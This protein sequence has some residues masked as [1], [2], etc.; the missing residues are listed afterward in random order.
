MQTGHGALLI[1]GQPHDIVFFLK[2][3]CHLNARSVVSQSS[4]K[5][6]YRAMANLILKMI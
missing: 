6:E 1:G 5:S 4:A 3:C 2:K